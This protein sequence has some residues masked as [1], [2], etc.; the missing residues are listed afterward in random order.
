[1]HGLETVAAQRFPLWRRYVRKSPSDPLMHARYLHGRPCT[2]A[3]RRWNAVCVKPGCKGA[4][5][6]CA[7]RLQGLDRW[8]DVDRPRI[9]ALLCDCNS[10]R[11]LARRAPSPLRRRSSCQGID[12]DDLASASAKLDAA[13]TCLSQRRLGA[14]RDHAG[15]RLRNATIC[16]SRNRPVAPRRKAWRLCSS[17]YGTN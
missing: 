8:P 10:L 12:A 11:M 13:L 6:R 1:M 16:W 9:R 14:G 17:S 4:Q 15:L 7:G 5:R 3:A 2:A